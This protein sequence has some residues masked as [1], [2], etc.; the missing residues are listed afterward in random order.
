MLASD[1]GSRSRLLPMCIFRS[2]IEGL[3]KAV[4][5]L[6]VHLYISRE[7]TGAF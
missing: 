3:A 2:F 7:L 1:N 5:G 4:R 6:P